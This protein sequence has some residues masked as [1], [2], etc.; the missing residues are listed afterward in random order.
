MLTLQAR[1]LS[2]ATR[3]A[4]LPTP[5]EPLPR[6]SRAIGGPPDLAVW[7]KRDD[8]TGLAG[9]GNKARKLEYLLADAL[10]QG[11]DTLVTLGAIQSNHARQTAAAAARHGLR[12]L[13]LLTD[14]VPH[15]GA[16]YHNGGNKLLSQILGAEIR[17]VPA[18]ADIA[19]LTTATLEALRA[20][21]QRPYLIPVGGSNDIGSFAYRDATLELAAQARALGRRIN[22]IVVATG[23]GG[24]H[25]G[26]AAGL[27]AAGLEGTRLHGISVSRSAEASAALVA[28]LVREI[29]ALEG[30]AGAAPVEL[31]IDDSQVGPGYGQP[32]P[33]MQE[34]VALLARSEGI[35]LDPVYT[36][37]AMAGLIAKAR[38]GVFAPGQM[39][40][41]WHTGGLPG[42]FAYPE[43]F[44]PG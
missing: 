18:E 4:S 13:L 5:L 44:A 39:V 8:C 6:F 24:T 28:P 34:A 22:H 10:A 32:T 9:G 35:L 38:G 30:R 25:A 41:F 21:G 19:A 15:R 20:A 31:E 3:L 16:T 42:L 1:V 2:G 33:A 26:I 29:Q 43:V 7:I 37:K 23:S 12:C 17:L 40:V 14:S 11:T 36:G 27:A